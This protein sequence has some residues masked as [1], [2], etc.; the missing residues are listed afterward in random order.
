M[1]QWNEHLR[2]QQ[3]VG[4]DSYGPK[5]QSLSKWLRR[6]CYYQYADGNHNVI[7]EKQSACLKCKKFI[8]L[9]LI[10]NSKVIKIR[11]MQKAA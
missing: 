4:V 10:F 1:S 9:R 7:T 3:Y 5:L 2:S 11:T 6:K 8:K